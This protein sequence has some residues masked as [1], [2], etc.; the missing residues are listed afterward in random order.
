M[1]KSIGC[2]KKSLPFNSGLPLKL[3]SLRWL[4]HLAHIT[5]FLL[6]SVPLLS[7]PCICL[8]H[9]RLTGTPPAILVTPRTVHNYY[10][11]SSQGSDSHPG[12]K[13]APFATAAKAESQPLNPGDHVYFYR[14]DSW[15]E[16]LNP[17]HSGAAG[18]PITF[19]DYGPAANAKP[20][21]WGSDQIPVNDGQWVA[22][23]GS[24]YTHPLSQQVNSVLVN[25]KFLVDIYNGGT[26]S[27]SVARDPSST[28]NCWKWSGGTLTLSTNGTNPNTDGRRYDVCVRE[29][30]ICNGNHASSIYES[31]LV[32]RNLVVDESAG[33]TSASPVLGY[34]IRIEGD[35]RN[36]S[37][38]NDVLVDGCEVYRYGRH[39]F[40]AIDSTQDIFSNCYCAY[41]MPNV[42]TG[43]TGY[44]SF[45]NQRPS[46]SE[47]SVYTNC[48]AEHMADTWPAQSG[49]GT[50]R[51]DFEYEAFTDHGNSLGSVTLNN[52]KAID[53]GGDG[54]G[55]NCTFDGASGAAVAVTGGGCYSAQV[56]TLGPNVH[57]SG[58]TLTGPYAG[59][60]ISGHDN[61]VENCLVA[62]TKNA[63]PYNSAIWIRGDRDIFQFN[64]VATDPSSG[65]GFS[66]LCLAS[67]GNDFGTNAQVYGNILLA[68]QLSLNSFTRT[69]TFSAP[70]V[71]DNVYTPGATFQLNYGTALSLPQWQAQGY[72]AGSL[73]A[74]QGAALFTSAA[75]ADF[76]LK[77]G[78]PAIDLVPLSLAYP[79]TDITGTARPDGRANDAG[80]YTYRARP[81]KKTVKKSEK[82]I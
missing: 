19:A 37:L 42:Q 70:N 38:G 17:L 25:Q 39:G 58:M 76:S 65:S 73:Q 10:V 43:Q 16:S 79:P 41:P 34:G 23:G 66:A 67:L 14:G 69:N 78:S 75:R 72:D 11:S 3:C 55:D 80:A 60:D 54:A 28:P 40:A 71:R 8:A 20:K 68:S 35:P 5:A 29:D 22:Q 47:T 77:S 31:H 32:F 62:G 18:S 63:A 52:F 12:T 33:G 7:M 24:V 6:L 36:L 26:G 46:L 81:V 1:L 74:A 2:H 45:G 56:S 4:T 59:M 57:I 61:L 50:D 15:R 49:T 64:T 53:T 27:G 9:A 51:S 44:V 21:F 82:K 13:T 48:T 30:V